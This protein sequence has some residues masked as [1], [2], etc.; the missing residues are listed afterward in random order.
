[1]GKS[2]GWGGSTMVSCSIMSLSQPLRSTETT[3]SEDLLQRA[4][5]VATLAVPSEV[6]A[7][8]DSPRYVDCRD[9]STASGVLKRGITS[10]SRR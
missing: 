1:M 10:F 5:S 9:R 4:E 3:V 2:M 7:C 6:S 8:L